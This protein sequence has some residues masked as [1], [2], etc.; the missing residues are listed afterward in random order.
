MLPTII[1]ALIGGAVAALVTGAEWL[2][3][4]LRGKPFAPSKWLGWLC[5]TAIIVSIGAARANNWFAPSLEA[6]M[7]AG[8]PTIAAVQK[9]YPDQFAQ[10]VAAVRSSNTPATDTTALRNLITPVIGQLVA[11]HANQIDETNTLAL[12]GLMTAEF[13]ALRDQYPEA[14]IQIMRGG[15]TNAP[16]GDVFSPEL[17]RQDTTVETG[18]L[19]QVATNPA[20]P[21]TPWPPAPMAALGNTALAALPSDERATVLPLLQNGTSPSTPAQYQAMCD[22]NIGLFSNVVSHPNGNARGFMAAY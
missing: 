1:G 7:V 17:I 4:K 22:F 12:F 11:S 16:L 9:Y 15:T 13:K 10:I 2:I 19:T 8:S 3:Q 6:Q 20:P 14:C 21:P 5:I 18:I